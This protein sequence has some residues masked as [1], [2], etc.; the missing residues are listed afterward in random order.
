MQKPAKYLVVI[1][2]AGEMVARMFDDQRRL[3]A[4]FDASSSEVAVMTQ[5][6]NPQR[7]AGDAVWNDALR[8]HSASER[9]E[10]EVYILDV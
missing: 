7:S 6:L 2:A 1:D 5:G 4:E 3:L 8:G 10:A 9:Q